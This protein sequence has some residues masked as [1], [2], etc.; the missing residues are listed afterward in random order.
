M[1]DSGLTRRDALR[2]GALV[3]GATIWAAPVVQSVPVAAFASGSDGVCFGCL[4]GGG[5]QVLGG[6][7]TVYSGAAD[8]VGVTY[9]ADISFGLS[10]ICCDKRP[11]TELEL[12]AHLTGLIHPDDPDKWHFDD[13][14]VVTCTRKGDP[15]MPHACANVFTGTIDQ[16]EKTVTK[17]N[18]T[19]HTPFAR[20]KFQL[21]DLGEGSK[22]DDEG[23]NLDTVYFEVLDAQGRTVAYAL[24]RLTK[25]N[26]QAHDDL[27][28]GG[29]DLPTPKVECDCPA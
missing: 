26:L 18:K 19:A 1:A 2:R 29:Q 10:P 16:P 24:G 20:L 6:S 8:L 4:T 28:P 11:G 17:G 3:A 12:N 5:M 9:S 15:G 7:Y 13:N 25:G 21:A 27:G 22:K 23:G 14:L